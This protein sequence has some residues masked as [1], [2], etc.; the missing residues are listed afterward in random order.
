V[1]LYLYSAYANT[2]AFPSLFT[3]CE[4]RDIKT[5]IGNEDVL[6]NSQTILVDKTKV[7][8]C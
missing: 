5:V 7:Q 6:Q 8:H 1:G 3:G 2:R 4:R